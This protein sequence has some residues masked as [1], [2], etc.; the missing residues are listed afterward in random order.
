VY[1]FKRV[2]AWLGVVKMFTFSALL[3]CL[4]SILLPSTSFIYWVLGALI[5]F[6]PMLTPVLVLSADVPVGVCLLFACEQV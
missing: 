4:G 5:A 2:L 6:V 3:L 1:A